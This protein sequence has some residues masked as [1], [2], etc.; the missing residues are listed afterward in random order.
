MSTKSRDN[1]RV[2]E[3]PSKGLGHLIQTEKKT[4]ERIIETVLKNNIHL[5]RVLNILIKNLRTETGQ[6]RDGGGGGL[7][8]GVGFS[9][10]KVFLIMRDNTNGGR[11]LVLVSSTCHL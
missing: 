5:H 10:F 9:R 7:R 6:G 3:S 2:R 1:F 8:D 11:V 4:N